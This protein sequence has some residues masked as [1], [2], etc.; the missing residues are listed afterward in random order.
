MQR[1]GEEAERLQESWGGISA[2]VDSIRARYGHGSVG[3]AAMVEA[4]GL[5]VRERGEA[6][7]GPAAEPDGDPDPPRNP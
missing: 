5:R 1:A 7:W 2:A 4:D 6:Q 3:S